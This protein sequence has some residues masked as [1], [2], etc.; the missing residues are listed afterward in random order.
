M[1]FGVPIIVRGEK[2]KRKVK[3]NQSL[4]TEQEEDDE[5]EDD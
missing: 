4:E 5:E 2:G 1:A 3:G